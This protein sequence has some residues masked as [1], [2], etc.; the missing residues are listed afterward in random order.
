[1]RRLLLLIVL[2][3]FACN[4]PSDA[5]D[6]ETLSYEASPAEMGASAATS[7]VQH[8]AELAR[9]RIEGDRVYV[10]NTVCAY[11][12]TPLHDEQLGE[13]TSEVVYDGPI[14]TFQG[15]TLVFN[16]CCPMC[17]DAFPGKWKD[18]RDEIMRFH[19]LGS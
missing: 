17:V 16:Q 13:Y 1:M 6:R 18:E 9:Y 14:K 10:N 3:L 19:G 2:A 11:S 12:R 7:A 5:V 8:P 15:K 4:P